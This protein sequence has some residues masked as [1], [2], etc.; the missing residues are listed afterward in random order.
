[1]A[2]LNEPLIQP[3]ITQ[4]GEIELKP[5]VRGKTKEVKPD[6]A[7][8]INDLAAKVLSAKTSVIKYKQVFERFKILA[9]SANLVVAVLSNGL[10]GTFDINSQKFVGNS[11]ELKVGLVT[12]LA[13][14]GDDKLAAVSGSDRSIMLCEISDNGITLK[15]ELK[16]HSRGVEM[17]Q[18][19]GDN[20]LYSCSLDKSVR[21]WD[22][23]THNSEVVYRLEQKP[24]VLATN[25]VNLIVG[26]NNG[27]IHSF[28]LTGQQD[29][30]VLTAHSSQVTAIKLS[31]TNKYV[32]TGSLNG[33]LC[34][35]DIET[36][37]MLWNTNEEKEVKS[38][39]FGPKDHYLAASFVK[40]KKLKVW[41]MIKKEEPIEFEGHKDDILCLKFRETGNHISIYTS[42]KDKTLRIWSYFGRS[43]EGLIES[44]NTD[45]RYRFI[46]YFNRTYI[47]IALENRVDIWNLKTLDAKG[48]NIGRKRVTQLE[49]FENTKIVGMDYNSVD[50]LF[51]VATDFG[52]IFLYNSNSW[53]RLKRK[54]DSDTH[55]GVTCVKFH[56]VYG[57][58]VTGGSDGKICFR[59]IHQLKV[60][61]ELQENADP[62]TCID[63]AVNKNLLISGSEDQTVSVWNLNDSNKIV[64]FEDDMFE[65]KGLKVTPD[66]SKVICWDVRSS[67]YIWNINDKLLESVINISDLG[68]YEKHLLELIGESSDNNR[69][70]DI[71]ITADQ[72]YML[73]PYTDSR[74]RIWSLETRTP[75]TFLNCGIVYNFAIDNKEKYIYYC[76]P[77]GLKVTKSPLYDKFFNVH[78]PLKNP[79]ETIHYLYQLLQDQRPG[80]YSPEMD[81]IFI[82][83]YHITM[84]NIYAYYGYLEHLKAHLTHHFSIIRDVNGFT[85]IN[86]CLDIKEFDSVDLLI[87]ALV[88]NIPIQ[89]YVSSLIDGTIIAL[90]EAGITSLNR[91]YEGLWITSTTTS[92]P[93]FVVESLSLPYE[94]F[95]DTIGIQK[96]NFLTQA[97][98]S[99]KGQAIVFKES[100]IK[101]NYAMGS[102]ESLSF[103]Y[104][105]EECSNEEIFR[106]PFIQQLLLYKWGKARMYATTQMGIYVLYLTLLILIDCN[107]L[108]ETLL[109]IL[110][111]TTNI[112]LF[113]FELFQMITD[114]KEYWLD[115][116]NN[117]DFA[118]NVLCFAFIIVDIQELSIK[119]EVLAVL[120]LI[121]FVRGMSYFRIFESTRYLIN[122]VFEVFKDM[123]AFLAL[124]IYCTLSYCFINMIFSRTRKLEPEQEPPGFEDSLSAA[125]KM[126]FG[127]FGDPSSITEWFVVTLMMLINPIVMLN[128]LISI[129]GDTYSRVQENSAIADMKELLEMIIEVEQL[130]YWRKNIGSQKYFQMLLSKESEEE[131]DDPLD[132]KLKILGRKVDFIKAE[133]KTYVSRLDKFESNTAGRLEKLEEIIHNSSEEQNA[134][135][136]GIITKVGE[137]DVLGTI[138]KEMSKKLNPDLDIDGIFRSKTLEAAEIHE[139]VAAASVANIAALPSGTVPAA[140]LARKKAVKKPRV[141][142]RI[143]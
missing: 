87:K 108:S 50:N 99:D 61:K 71:Y 102:Q 69:I 111:I 119:D 116:W 63:F 27:Q 32:A 48:K 67:I 34:V 5:L 57:H 21:V 130:L 23:A 110:L 41:N 106:T 43:E 15:A 96:L 100:L 24:R 142:G 31:D 131:I 90:N 112:L 134:K 124:L 2:S 3:E 12:S 120:T 76:S 22:L 66:E 139:P 136:E 36:L 68:V 128:L 94:H 85:P 75:V 13:V 4:P 93:K 1:M 137:F 123:T 135:I 10:I 88:N 26:D 38:I 53:V 39:S 35:W 97:D 9:K 109:L 52:G 78:N 89:K 33:E 37:E 40:N 16:G 125:Y 129:L 51:V 58:I 70:V 95:S 8:A 117:I 73:I 83:P 49:G 56:P 72:R 60:F 82:A 105:L 118:R 104:S 107:L 7:G 115:A 6:S 19:I 143:G 47:A 59:D 132:A 92:L 29:P 79:T 86:T 28:S 30:L 54:K 91:L 46:L 103:L 140:R 101:Q 122:L 138:I 74:L 25:G 127:D 17:V 114:F 121:S 113:S 55:S 141:I 81:Y 14:S 62:I 42:S 84:A 98:I 80:D 44:Y 65:L 64:S 133:T 77:D 18:F 11:L 126:N 20:T 45:E